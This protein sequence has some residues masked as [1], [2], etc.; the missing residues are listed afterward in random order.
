MSYDVDGLHAGIWVFIDDM[1]LVDDEDHEEMAI[2][3]DIFETV[4]RDMVSHEDNAGR[5]IRVPEGIVGHFTYDDLDESD[6]EDSLHN[7]L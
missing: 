2:P 3:W 5:L 6:L 4:A 1:R 7:H